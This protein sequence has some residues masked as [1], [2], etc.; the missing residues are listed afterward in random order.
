MNG[1]REVIIIGGGPAG[2]TA[3][4]YLAR[5]KLAPLMLNSRS[6]Q[7]MLT[8]EVENFPGFKDGVG[9]VE[10]MMSMKQ[11]AEKFGTEIL[12]REVTRVDFSG[13]IKRFML[14]TFRQAQ[15]KSIWR[16]Q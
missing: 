2:F 4:L 6:C 8:S 11:Q 16:E 1:V 7:L 3:A 14:E 5:A 15:S 13:E 12:E 9:G 10:L